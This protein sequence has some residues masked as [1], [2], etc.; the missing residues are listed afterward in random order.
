MDLDFYKQERFNFEKEISR[1]G[2]NKLIHFT[3]ADNLLPVVLL[4]KI[5]SREHIDKI[6]EECKDPVVLNFFKFHD[7]LR[8]DNKKDYVSLS[9]E[10]PNSFMFKKKREEEGGIWCVIEISPRLLLLGDTLF[11]IYNAASNFSINKEIG[12]TFK[13]FSALFLDKIKVT[14][15]YGDKLFTR[16]GLKDSY[17]TT[18]QA[19]VLVKDRV[20]YDD[21][22]NICFRSQEDLGI[23][24]KRMKKVIHLKRGRGPYIDLKKFSVH[25][26][27]WQQK[28][29]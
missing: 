28:R 6:H 26:E 14:R 20:L 3:S 7:K 13:H 1:R 19:E 12:P 22:L 29:K 17:P 4:K 8:L 23:I 18:D 25:P 24:K 15:F 10:F 5:S 27:Y 16:D 9:I 21:F 11:S 2:I